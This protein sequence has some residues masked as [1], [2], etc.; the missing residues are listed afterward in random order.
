MSKFLFPISCFC[1]RV[2]ETRL[3]VGLFN[4]FILIYRQN[5]F[6]WQL[7]R[8]SNGQLLRNVCTVSH[9]YMNAKMVLF[10]SRTDQRVENLFSSI[11]SHVSTI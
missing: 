7:E 10:N 2:Q 5:C 9:K 8:L 11:R 6:E 1:S 4:K 3:D